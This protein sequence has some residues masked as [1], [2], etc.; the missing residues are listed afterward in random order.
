M[1]VKVYRVGVEWARV[2]PQPGVRSAEG[3]AFYDDLI[4]SIVDAGMHR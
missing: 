3:E 4:A 2:E 1:G